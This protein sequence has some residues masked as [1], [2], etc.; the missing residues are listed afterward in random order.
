MHDR[1]VPFMLRIYIPVGG[2]NLF[3]MLPVITLMDRH[4]DLTYL[5]QVFYGNESMVQEIVQLFL[6]Q[7]PELAT[8][9]TQCVRLARWQDLHPLAHKLKSSVTMLGMSDLAPIVLEIEQVSKFGRDPALLPQLVSNLNVH[10]EM[11]TLSLR[12]DLMETYDPIRAG[13][14]QLRRA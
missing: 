4:Y 10:L 11:V 6:D 3:G 12:R 14:S 13:S 1:E 2:C 8:T 5:N 9:M 7:A